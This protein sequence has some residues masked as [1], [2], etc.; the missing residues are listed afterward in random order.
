[1]ALT[2]RRRRQQQPIPVLLPRK[3]HRRR[4]LVQATVRGVSKS[5]A[6]LSD[7]T[8]LHTYST[9]DNQLTD[10]KKNSF[11]EVFLLVNEKLKDLQS[12]I[13]K[14]IQIINSNNCDVTKRQPNIKFLLMEEQN[15]TSAFAKSTESELE[16]ASRF[17]CP[18]VDHTEMC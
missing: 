5:R 3:S 10:Q 9:L 6:R 18:C 1:M 15:T 8:S 12:P 17:K 2:K 16:N 4:S 11:I 13:N 7:F 14:W